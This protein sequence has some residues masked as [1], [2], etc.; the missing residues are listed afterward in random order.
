MTEQQPYYFVE[1]INDTGTMITRLPK[2]K[3]EKLY[4]K[5]RA[6]GVKANFYPEPFLNGVV[7]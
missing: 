1:E 6:K 5:L 3:A 7:R 2:E 4:R